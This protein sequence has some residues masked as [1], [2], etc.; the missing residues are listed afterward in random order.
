MRLRGAKLHR[1]RTGQL[2]PLFSG[3]LGA[4][5]NEAGFRE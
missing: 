2:P 3:L 5:A 4:S 1:P